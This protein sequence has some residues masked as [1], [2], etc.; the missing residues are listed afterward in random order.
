M[1]PEMSGDSEEARPSAADVRIA[2]KRWRAVAGW[3]WDLGMNT[4]C[5]ICRN[6]IMELCI[7]CQ[8]NYGAACNDTCTVAWGECGHAFHFHCISKW[9]QSRHVCPLDNRDWFF[10]KFETMRT[11]SDSGNTESRRSALLCREVQNDEV[12]PG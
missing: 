4:T 8:A 9:L 2:L 12:S 11:T 7:E 3:T 10:V 5:A 1:F 6:E